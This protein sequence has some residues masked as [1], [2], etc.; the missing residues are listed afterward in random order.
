VADAEK[1]LQT[2]GSPTAML[3][4]TGGFVSLKELGFL[5]VA[6]ATNLVL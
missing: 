2:L 4:D 5:V 6:F 3:S 1:D